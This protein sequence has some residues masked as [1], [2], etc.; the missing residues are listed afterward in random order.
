[1]ACVTTI[2][3]PTTCLHVVD[4]ESWIILRSHSGSY[5]ARNIVPVAAGFVK[6]YI[7]SGA[8]MIPGFGLWRPA[9]GETQTE[10]GLEGYSGSKLVETWP[11][12]SVLGDFPMVRLSS[13]SIVARKRAAQ[14]H[15]TVITRNLPDIA[16]TA[17]LECACMATECRSPEDRGRALSS[18]G[19]RHRDKIRRG[20]NGASEQD[21]PPAQVAFKLD[22]VRRSGEPSEH[23]LHR[24]FGRSEPRGAC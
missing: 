18:I 21:V 14:A 12:L 6:D 20:A 15:P 1:M 2:N 23:N 10:V 11:L 5:L 13:G 7:A 24:P 4:V 19:S 3:L 16:P 9:Q 17:P 22:L 8:L